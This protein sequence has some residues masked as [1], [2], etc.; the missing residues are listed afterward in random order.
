MTLNQFYATTNAINAVTSFT[1]G[2]FIL[3]R[4]PRLRLHQLWWWMSL[5][6]TMWAT[7][8]AIHFATSPSNYDLALSALR[9]A[10]TVAIF[11]PLFYL[12]FIVVFLERNDQKGV[13]KICYALSG[14]LACFGF[15][16]IYISGLKTKLGIINY[17]HAGPLFWAFWILYALEPIYAICL[18]WRAKQTAVGA[19]RTHI[20][21]VM[22]AGI[23][24]FL[25]G[26]TW[27]PLCFDIPIPPVGGPLIWLYCLFV[28]WA[29]FKYHLFDIHVVIRR[30]L[31]YSILITILTAGYFGLVYGIERIFQT[32]FGYKSVWVS[33]TAF[34][35]MAL[36]F[37]P[38]KLWIQRWVDWL[39][40]RAPQEEVAKRMERLE[41]DALQTEKLR[42][43]STLAAG[44]AHEIKN[45]LTAIKTFTEFIPEKQH[46]PQFLKQLHEVLS[47]EV[48]RVQEI[49]Q[50]V[51]DFAKP[52]S[53]QLKPV[54]L[55]SLISST[56]NLLS[57]ELSKHQIRWTVACQHNGATLN[58]DPDQL[59]QVLINLIQNASDAM[60]QGGSLAVS[61]Q[62]INGQL[63][64][65][66]TDTG[67]GI[68][69][70]L[71]SRIFDPFV[72]TKSHG[73]GLGL[74]MVHNIIQAHRGTVHVDS[75]S[76]RGTTFTIRLPL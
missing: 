55:G 29:V 76:G 49:V 74:A 45:P 64:L 70:D 22:L 73:T 35:L 15:S 43:V 34:A 3:L 72:T 65:K 4:N 68:P 5:A 42:A 6:I 10:D 51:L 58:A 33:L 38:L 16:P 47:T 54:D 52:K 24:G 31:V 60:P 28:A 44:M 23:F 62:S 40:F 63:E 18:I 12:H 1:L 41:Q 20:T 59:R 53:P 36:A 7:S 61:T 30:S 69:A 8:I 50:E 25:V 71:I 75:H 13:L 48:K 46:D 32:A 11:I 2:L 67:N 57:G 39:I 17:N 14:L 9:F 56:I 19:R 66:I 21:Y 27:F 37:Q 26:A